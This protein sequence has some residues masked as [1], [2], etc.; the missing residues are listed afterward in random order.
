MFLQMH[1]PTVLPRGIHV[2]DHAQRRL[3]AGPHTGSHNGAVG[4]E[5]VAG[6]NRMGR[7]RKRHRRAGVAR[8]HNGGALPYADIRRLS[9]NIEH[10][11][12]M[13]NQ[14]QHL[15]AV[16]PVNG[17]VVVGEDIHART[18]LRRQRKTVR[19]IRAARTDGVLHKTVVLGVMPDRY[20][21]RIVLASVIG[22][23]SNDGWIV[24]IL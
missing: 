8:R 17:G 7:G 6:L 22:G 20:L 15:H 9:S 4:A 10:G 23:N 16:A 21:G 12:I 1:R 13:D 5:D 18:L 2:E 11:G 14:L 19:D 24:G 3:P